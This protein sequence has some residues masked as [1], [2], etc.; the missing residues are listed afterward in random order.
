MAKTQPA[1]QRL[2]VIWAES[3][4]VSAVRMLG[5][6]D[7]GAVR[8]GVECASGGGWERGVLFAIPHHDSRRERGLARG[9]VWSWDSRHM[10]TSVVWMGLLLRRR[11]LIPSESRLGAC[12]AGSW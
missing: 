9:S 3:R 12:V 4:L 10:Q 2:A 7:D 5:K 11:T 1:M 6:V 8:C